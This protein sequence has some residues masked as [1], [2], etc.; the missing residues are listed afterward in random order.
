[1]YLDFVFLWNPEHISCIKFEQ[2]KK[3]NLN[4]DRGCL[5]T[6]ILLDPQSCP[7][8]SKHTDSFG[9]LFRWVFPTT[10]IR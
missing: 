2:L 6:C 1:M 9:F 8:P 3:E 4:L 10:L 7:T 5:G